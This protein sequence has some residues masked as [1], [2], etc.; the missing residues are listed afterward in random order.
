MGT[1]IGMAV[2]TG[3]DHHH[4]ETGIDEITQGEIIIVT[5]ETATTAGATEIK[6]ETMGETG[7]REVVTLETGRTATEIEVLT[8]TE[9]R[10]VTET[11]SLAPMPTARVTQVPESASGPGQ[12]TDHAILAHATK[13]HQLPDK[14]RRKGVP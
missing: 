8:A 2:L 14:P 6:T 13:A 9:T 10:T 4:D 5:I 3:T 12:E 1:Q 7:A 11:V